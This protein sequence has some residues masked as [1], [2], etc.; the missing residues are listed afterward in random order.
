MSFIPDASFR[1]IIA[2][3]ASLLL[4]VDLKGQSIKKNVT[5]CIL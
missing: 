5:Y 1:G 4:N 2:L 3:R